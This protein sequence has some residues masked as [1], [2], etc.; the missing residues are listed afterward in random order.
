[1]I[2]NPDA[3]SVAA[4]RLES[5]GFTMAAQD[6]AAAA[7]TSGVIPAAADPISAVQATIFSAYGSQYQSVAAQ[8]GIVNTCGLR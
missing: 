4:S 8:G 7:H 2:A 3:S 5:L 1:M 6:A